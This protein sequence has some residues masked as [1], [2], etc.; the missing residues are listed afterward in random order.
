LALC[1]PALGGD[2]T[3]AQFV[4]KSW[5]AKDGA[6]ANIM[7][8]TQ[9][10]DG[11]LWLAS[12]QGLYRFDGMDFERL[13]PS[14]QPFTSASVYS[15][16]SCPNGDLW[17][18]SAVSGISKLRNGTNRNYTTEDGFP[19]GAVLSIAQDRQ[20]AIW[21]GTQGGLARF[22]G[23]KWRKVGSESGFEGTPISLYVDRRGTLWA[24]SLKAV[25]FLPQGSGSFRRAGFPT[26]YVMHMLESP[27][28]TMWMAQTMRAVRPMPPSK[29]PEIVLG[30]QRILFD[31]DGSL[32]ITTLGDGLRRA[33][34]PDRLPHEKIEKSSDRLESFT[35]K[36]GLSADFVT[37][38]YQDREGNIWVGT[39]GGLDRFSRGAVTRAPVPGKFTRT[40]MAPGDHGDV[41][42]GGLSADVGRIH[43]N[44]WFPEVMPFSVPSVVSAPDGSTWWAGNIRVGR[45]FKGRFTPFQLPQTYVTNNAEPTRIAIDRLGI[46]WI[47]GSFGI[48]A[49]RGSEWKGIDLPSGFPGKRAV[50][51]YA[52]AAGRVWFGYRENSIVLIDRGAVRAFSSKDGLQ[53]GAVQAIFA[54]GDCTWIGGSKGL[55]LFDGRRFRDIT[56]AGGGSFGSV[57]GVLE[58]SDGYLWLNAY[59]GIVRM[60]PA[61]VAKLKAGTDRA[62][63]SLF[64]AYDGLPGATQQ[65]QPYPTLI[66]ATDGKLW[67]GTSAGPVWIDP[68]DL[69]RNELPP[70]VAIRSLTAKGKRYTS[71]AALRLPALTRDVDFGYT[72]MSLT[73]PERVRF[74]YKLDGSDE[75]WHDAGTR[76][77]A[78]YT[79]LRPG[80]YRFRVMAC[81]N[82]GVW[83]EAGAAMTFRI[84]AAF[85]QTIWFQAVCYAAGLALLWLLYRFR[86][87]Q[88]TAQVHS[89]LEGRIAERDRIAREL[90]DT[91]LQSFQG[92]MLRLQ[93]VD[94]L[95]PPGEAKEELDQSLE[96]ADQAIAEGRRAVY[97]LRS[98]N[99]TANDLKEA[100]RAAA[101]KFAGDGS[102]TF[103]LEA[104]G[105]ARDLHPIM[106]DEVYRIACEGL[107]NAFKHARAQHV[108]VEITYGERVLRLRIRDDGDGIPRDILESG[109]SGHYGL[110]GMR[111]RAQQNGATLEI[112]S[113]PK[114]GTEIELS[115]PASIAYANS[116]KRSSWRLFRRRGTRS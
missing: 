115:I 44:Q 102:P 104:E 19:D 2:R 109:R 81:N 71:F 57:S 58:T 83:N 27:D 23:T 8:I 35:A 37:S 86:L 49:R 113:R 53:A 116:S 78:F 7:A 105:A 30:S 43:D 29:G 85:Y 18:G 59:N 47:S 114:A 28:G 9:T 61:V 80:P 20:G 68:K 48:F 112:W 97:D 12:S 17:I 98:T 100:L 45:E 31:R 55:Q 90:H 107:R 51:A 41:W 54:S 25:F 75:D 34:Y 36:E 95:L 3:I 67:F 69:P 88:A 110:R 21:A 87:Q 42:V 33:P 91:L 4:H 40:T 13:E 38:I 24:A 79:N 111:E 74:R 66:Q 106:H 15:L 6:P 108:E 93:V 32:W 62:E 63:Y 10:N 77:Q 11:Y 60:P 52:D 70:P 26:M 39:S 65:S 1:L 56:P 16:V 46:L 22:D 5:V 82:D 101:D 14:G 84:D 92:L 76:R 99:T 50:L 64:D 73:I 89:R 94:D 96:R 103:S 72:A